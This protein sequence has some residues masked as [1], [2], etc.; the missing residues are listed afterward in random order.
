M[1]Q[2]GGRLGARCPGHVTGRPGKRHTRVI[3]VSGEGS[4]ASAQGGPGCCPDVG[5]DEAEPSPWPRLPDAAPTMAIQPEEDTPC[6][7]LLDPR[8]SPKG[9]TWAILNT[10]ARLT[11]PSVTC[12]ASCPLP[13]DR[14]WPRCSRLSRVPHEDAFPPGGTCGGGTSVG[15]QAFADAIELGRGREG[16]PHTCVTGVLIER[17][18]PDA[19]TRSWKGG[20]VRMKTEMF[21]EAQVCPR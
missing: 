18:C 16:E 2:A 14:P 8:P 17:G 7:R 11:G 9:L 3:S 10:Q 19:R 20:H 15:N 12:A 4:G 6:G 21:L 5:W 1:T 13:Q